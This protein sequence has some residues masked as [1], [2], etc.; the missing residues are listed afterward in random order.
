MIVGRAPAGILGLG[1]SLSM[2]ALGSSP[3][4]HLPCQALVHGLAPSRGCRVVGK[5]LGQGTWPAPSPVV[6]GL[7]SLCQL[8]GRHR[9]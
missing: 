2:Q 8:H 7:C 9:C 6:Q 1:S 3:F 5:A 4:S